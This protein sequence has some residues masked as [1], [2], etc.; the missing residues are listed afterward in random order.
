MLFAGI[1]EGQAEIYKP[2]GKVSKRDGDFLPRVP[3]AGWFHKG[4]ADVLAIRGDR[5]RRAIAGGGITEGYFLTAFESKAVIFG[6]MRMIDC[7]EEWFLVG[8][9]NLG[10]VVRGIGFGLNGSGMEADCRS[11][12]EWRSPSAG[13]A[14]IG[15]ICGEFECLVL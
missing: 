3:I 13:A 5:H 2:G 7:S 6:P 8:V 10:P 9:E 12:G 14:V 15:V 1:G 4:G 11:S